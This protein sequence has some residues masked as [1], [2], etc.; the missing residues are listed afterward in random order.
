MKVQQS[1]RD[2]VVEGIQAKKTTLAMKQELMEDGLTKTQANCCVR[3]QRKKI[4]NSKKE[5]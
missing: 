4:K 3:N 2:K 1:H 5:N